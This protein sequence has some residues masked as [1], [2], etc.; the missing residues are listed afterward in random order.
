[1]ASAMIGGML[2]NG[3]V[4]VSELIGSAKTEATRQRAQERFGI[5]TAESNAETAEWAELVVLAVKPQ[6]FEEVIGQIRQLD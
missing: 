3:L 2:K 1:M 5:R 4:D 6:F